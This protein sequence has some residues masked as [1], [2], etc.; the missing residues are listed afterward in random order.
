MA[1]R[2]IVNIVSGNEVSDVLLP[3]G[4]KPFAE[5]VPTLVMTMQFQNTNVPLM[6]QQ[7]GLGL[8]SVTWD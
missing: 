7:L 3:D 8:Y 5:P 4:T 6:K 1:S 2:S